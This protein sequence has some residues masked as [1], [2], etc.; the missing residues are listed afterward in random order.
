MITVIVVHDDGSSSDHACPSEWHLR[1]YLDR[2]EDLDDVTTV[3][4]VR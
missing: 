3:I 2:V 1:W 4:V